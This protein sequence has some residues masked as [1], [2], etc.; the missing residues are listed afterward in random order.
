MSVVARK[1]AKILRENKIYKMSHLI[2][3]S[4]K[5]FGLPESQ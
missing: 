2:P 3:K 5:E 1:T 4:I